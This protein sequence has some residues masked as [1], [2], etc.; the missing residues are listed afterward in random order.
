MILYFSF[1]FSK[2]NM[3]LLPSLLLFHLDIINI[4]YFVILEFHTKNNSQKYLFRT[5]NAFI[6]FLKP[7]YYPYWFLEN[8]RWTFELLITFSLT[9]LF[10]FP[11]FPTGNRNLRTFS[12]SSFI[13][14]RNGFFLGWFLKVLWYLFAVFSYVELH[15][16][17]HH[18]VCPRCFVNKMGLY[19]YHYY[20]HRS[21]LL[22][23]IFLVVKSG[24]EFAN[25]IFTA[26]SWYMRG[27]ARIT[28]GK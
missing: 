16:K 27:V 25:R 15:R 2:R 1:S 6:Y 18:C 24:V 9:W 26:I 7:F 10:V 23:P 13:L 21:L 22:F 17:Y 14:I 12:L 11:D 20:H 8:Y 19:Y 3:Q 28:N 5:S 4:Q